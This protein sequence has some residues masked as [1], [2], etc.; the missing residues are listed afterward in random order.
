MQ[1]LKEVQA[2]P[3]GAVLFEHCEKFGFEGVVSKRLSSRYMSGPSRLWTKT[4]CR[5]WKRANEGR[6]KLFEVARNP[7]P[8]LVPILGQIE[9]VVGDHIPDREKFFT[10]G[11]E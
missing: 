7:E 8:M 6:H 11:S 10:C 3:D 1:F 4:K 2:F 5:G 9:A